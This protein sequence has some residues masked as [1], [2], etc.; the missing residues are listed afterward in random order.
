MTNTFKVFERNDKASGGC[1]QDGRS[2]GHAFY[3][4][5]KV[6]GEDC[7]SGNCNPRGVGYAVDIDEEYWVT[8]DENGLNLI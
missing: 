8:C 1:L 4:S 7:Y 6:A 5:G 2:H 3:I